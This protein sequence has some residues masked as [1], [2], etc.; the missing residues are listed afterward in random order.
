MEYLDGTVREQ[1]WPLS[2]L[3]LDGRGPPDLMMVPDW[4]R[5]QDMHVQSTEDGRTLREGQVDMVAADGTVL[6]LAMDGVF[7]RQLVL[8][9]DGVEAWIRPGSAR[10]HWVVNGQGTRDE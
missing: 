6:W 1:A 9:A 10:A 7:G 8:R 2:E 5:L 4:S 3:R